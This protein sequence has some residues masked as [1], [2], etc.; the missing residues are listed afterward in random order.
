[1][2]EFKKCLIVSITL[3]V[4]IGIVMVI[5]FG[6]PDWGDNTAIFFRS[7]RGLRNP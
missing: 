1:M 6:W 4:I 3:S 7:H 2:T 5:V